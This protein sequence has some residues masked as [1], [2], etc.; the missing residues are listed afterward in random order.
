MHLLTAGTHWQE[1]YQRGVCSSTPT[2]PLLLPPTPP[3]QWSYDYGIH[4]HD[5]TPLAHRY[6]SSPTT[7]VLRGFSNVMNWGEQILPNPPHLRQIDP[8]DAPRMDATDTGHDRKGASLAAE[9]NAAP[10]LLSAIESVFVNRMREAFL[11]YQAYYARE[12]AAHEAEVIED[13]FIIPILHFSV[14]VCVMEVGSSKYRI[15]HFVVSDII[16]LPVET[17]EYPRYSSFTNEHTLRMYPSCFCDVLV[18]S[19]HLHVGVS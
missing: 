4:D 6:F 18:G 14:H 3:R 7:H 12:R 13:M 10:T 2:P 11:G 19:R 9:A 8:Q 16:M 15:V 5:Y 1:F 17:N